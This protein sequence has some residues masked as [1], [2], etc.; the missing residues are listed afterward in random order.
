MTERVS[1]V[2]VPYSADQM[3]DLVA[4]IEAYPEFIPWCRALRVVKTE[5]N[6]PL[7]EK[8]SD[9]VVA[10]KSF[11]EKFRSIATFNHDEYA[12]SA[13]YLEGPF[14]RLDTDWQFEGMG[15]NGCRIHFRIAFAFRNFL[16]QATA[17]MI[18]D[19]AFSRMTD[20][21]IERADDL[22]GNAG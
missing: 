7:T 4:D 22:Y 2:D 1:H 6:G 20:A 17:Q 19:R 18:F 12:I 5:A 11:R 3:F 21:F 14:E 15:E 13:H 8:T 9:M 10:Y 16:L